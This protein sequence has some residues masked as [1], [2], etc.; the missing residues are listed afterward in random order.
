MKT[1]KTIS[2]SEVKAL[3]S[4]FVKWVEGTKS[5]LAAVTTIVERHGFRKGN[6][7]IVADSY[8]PQAGTLAAAILTGRPMK[9]K[10]GS[11]EVKPVEMKMH[12][13]TGDDL[14]KGTLLR[15]ELILW[16]ESKGFT[17]MSQTVTDAFHANGIC[18]R[19]SVP[20]GSVIKTI[21]DIKDAA[22]KARAQELRELI[23]NMEDVEWADVP[24]MLRG[25]AG[26]LKA[27]AAV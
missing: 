18:L 4:A 10:A 24:D 2:E 12:K 21:D 11:K 25:L 3:D 5:M 9:G 16:G 14:E 13:L 1:Y 27:D 17:G 8:T 23:A 7:E 19:W 6:N 15:K 22:V 20:G 26:T